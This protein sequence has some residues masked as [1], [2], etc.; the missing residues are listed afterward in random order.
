[1][2]DA[3]DMLVGCMYG[4]HLSAVGLSGCADANSMALLRH[5]CACSRGLKHALKSGTAQRKEQRC[6]RYMLPMMQHDVT[7]QQRILQWDL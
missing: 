7:R 4:R 2:T 3:V 5:I 1:M 6:T